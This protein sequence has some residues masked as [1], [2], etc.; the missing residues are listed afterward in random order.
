MP[1]DYF[2]TRLSSAQYL[3]KVLISYEDGMPL[4]RIRVWGTGYCDCG[5]ISSFT[6]ALM[7]ESMRASFH[8]EKKL[9]CDKGWLG[10]GD[11]ES[12]SEPARA[13]SAEVGG[14]NKAM[15]KVARPSWETKRPD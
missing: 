1:D 10:R 7:L 8:L 9:N 13:G 4:R 11:P 3:M 15:K 6:P 2:T 5:I 12:K 14:M